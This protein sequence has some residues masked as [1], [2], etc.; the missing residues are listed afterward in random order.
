M[1]RTEKSI[2]KNKETKAL[3]ALLNNSRT[4]LQKNGLSQKFL[5]A[6]AHCF[7]KTL[8]PNFAGVYNISQANYRLLNKG[9]GQEYSCILNLCTDKDVSDGKVGHYVGI[10]KNK[11]YTLYLDPFGLPVL[12]NDVA[13]IMLASKGEGRFFYNRKRVQSAN[14]SFCGLYA[15]LFLLKM[16]ENEYLRSKNKRAKNLIFAEDD[17]GG[18]NDERCV[19]YL[20]ELVQN[21]MNDDA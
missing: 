18:K 20:I 3:E 15:L 14:S 5:N 1:E 2:A 6:L 21:Y 8:L 10:I 7:P 17:A 11:K 19:E 9:M 16:H 13:K 12:R 4:H